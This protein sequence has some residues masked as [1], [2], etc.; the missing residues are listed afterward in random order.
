[1]ADVKYIGY[2]LLCLIIITQVYVIPGGLQLVEIVAVLAVFD[3]PPKHQDTGSVHHKPKS[4]TSRGNV[5]L[6]GRYK[7]LV[8]RWG[9]NV[10][11]LDSEPTKN[12]HQLRSSFQQKKT[13]FSDFKGAAKDSCCDS[14]CEFKTAA[15]L[16]PGMVYQLLAVLG[17]GLA[18]G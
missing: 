7:P 2:H 18:H 1:M 6:D 5:S 8:C 16:R 9:E 17:Y 4:S 10:L 13:T 3:H 11:S 12:P 14:L 15:S